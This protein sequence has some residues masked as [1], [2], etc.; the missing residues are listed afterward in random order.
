MP[1][2]LNRRQFLKYAVLTAGSAAFRPV[3]GNPEDL[4][5]DDLARIAIR[6]VSVHAQPNEDSVI[7]YQLYRDELVNIYYEEESR[8]GP[9]YNP[10]WYRVWGGW[11]HRSNTQRVSPKLNPTVSS[12]L[13]DGQLAEVTVPYSQAMRFLGERW[14]WQQLYR[15]YYGSTHW[16]MG[17]DDG[18]DGGPW[19]RLKDELLEVEY[20]V[21]AAHL[22]LVP[23]EEFAPISPD[24]PAHKKRIEVSVGRQELK[25]F[26][27]DQ[28][29]FETRISSGLNRHPPGEIPWETPKGSFN[30][31]SKMPSKHMGDGRLT[32]NPEDYELPG[33]PWTSFFEETGVAFHGTW[34]HTDFGTPRSHG[35]VNMRTEEAKWLFRWATPVN[36]PGT[37]EQRGNG[38][39]VIVT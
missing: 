11:I 28:V 29:V 1:P 15:L 3:F 22:R 37:I 27:Y 16:V 38:T 33:V 25:A 19:Y 5:G 23:P 26:E 24:V 36:E 32:G 2:K 13:P 9:G 10:I 17:L 18:P 21:P 12:L 31:F 7:K 8:H 34:W 6:Q 30:V 35:C 14:G 39:R 20:H 4:E